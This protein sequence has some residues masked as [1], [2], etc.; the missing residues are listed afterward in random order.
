MFNVLQKIILQTF[1]FHMVF[2]GPVKNINVFPGLNIEPIVI[3]K[4]FL[5]SINKTKNI[6]NDSYIL[7]SNFEDMNYRKDYIQMIDYKQKSA[8]EKADDLYADYDNAARI[9]LH[10]YSNKKRNSAYINRKR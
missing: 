4:D 3:N 1:L 9:K 5:N 8:T 7:N 6:K 10:D 2:C